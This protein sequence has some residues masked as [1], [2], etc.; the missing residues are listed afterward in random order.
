MD[1]MKEKT[2]QDRGLVKRL[3]EFGKK[4]KGKPALRWLGSAWASYLKFYTSGDESFRRFVLLKLDIASQL[5]G[6]ATT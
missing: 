2:F 5:E 4:A 1:A 6:R 3:R